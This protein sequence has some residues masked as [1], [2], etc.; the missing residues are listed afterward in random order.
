MESH[1]KYKRP[2][3][4]V[5]VPS[6]QWALA[7]HFKALSI[8]RWWNLNVLLC[9]YLEFYFI[10]WHVK[11]R[12]HSAHCPPSGL[13]WLANISLGP[14]ALSTTW[15]WWELASNTTYVEI[16]AGNSIPV[17]TRRCCRNIVDSLRFPPRLPKRVSAF[18]LSCKTPL[19]LLIMLTLLTVLAE[20]TMVLKWICS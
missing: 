9:K 12:K 2:L 18:N 5:N 17:A 19:Q 10:F 20:L 7:Q 13:H 15:A 3:F 4:L 6:T 1:V 11:M 14:S 8:S 16:T